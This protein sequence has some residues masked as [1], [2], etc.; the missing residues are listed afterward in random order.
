MCDSKEQKVNVGEH[1]VCLAAHLS[2]FKD[3]VTSEILLNM[4][5]ATERLTADLQKFRGSQMEREI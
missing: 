1:T 5:K 2:E 4:F 3:Q